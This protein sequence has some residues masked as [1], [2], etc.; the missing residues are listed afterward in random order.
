MKPTYYREIQQGSEEWLQIRA[1]RITGTDAATLLVNGKSANGLGTGAMGL[2]YKKAAEFVTG[3][4]ESG[5]VNYA[6]QRGT[7][8]EPYARAE[9]E[10]RTWN[11]VEQVGFVSVGE[12][13]GVSPDG[14]VGYDGII[15]I[16]CP[17]GAEFV[18]F[19]D[20]KE[21]PEAHIAQ[22][23]WALFLTGRKWCDYV[24]FNPDFEPAALHVVR[25][26]PATEYSGRFMDK[27][28]VWVQE[29]ERVLSLL[30]IEKMDV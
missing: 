14:L 19:V 15:E 26:H 18:R 5:F 1:G 28:T 17:M 10:T 27:I 12:Y 8:L 9:Y 20:T 30:A 23:Q 7:E 4:E 16:K 29:L 25:V 13:F 22:M 11:H 21:I 2:L 3:P 24:V 6:M